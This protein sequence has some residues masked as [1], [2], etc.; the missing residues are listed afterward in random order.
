MDNTQM[1]LEKMEK[2]SRRQLAVT[3]ILCI[4]CAAVLVCSL[5]LMAAVMGTAKQLTALAKPLQEITVQVQDMTVQAETVMNNM[6]TVT[7]ALA[8]ADLG[9]MVEDVNT[10]TND[11]QII[12]TEAM[13]KLDAIDIS[14]LNKAIQ[15]LA[16]IVAPLANISNFFG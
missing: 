5:V 11:S 4:L 9:S 1:I 8:D 7:Q 16:D 12:V 10:L 6:E 15:D 13:E 14:S 2:N 3:R